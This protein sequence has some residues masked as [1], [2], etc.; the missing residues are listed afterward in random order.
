[1]LLFYLLFFITCCNSAKTRPNLILIMADDS[2]LSVIG[3]YTEMNDTYSTVL[4]DFVSNPNIDSI[5]DKGVTFT[6]AAVENSICSPARQA[7]LSGTFTDRHGV[8][9][10]SCSASLHPDAPMFPAQLNAVG[11]NLIYVPYNRS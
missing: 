6:Q 8:A 1:M 10:V 3:R 5:W 9:C 7:V 4:K 11:P 2:A